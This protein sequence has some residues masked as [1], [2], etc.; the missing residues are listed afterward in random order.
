MARNNNYNALLKK[1]Q[2][3]GGYAVIKPNR[4]ALKT[5]EGFVI[6]VAAIYESA[7]DSSPLKA[8][9]TIFHSYDVEDYLT[10]S[11]IKY[12]STRI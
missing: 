7:D 5:K 6:W 11:D 10:D 9:D 8:I 2:E 3:K 12:L 4:P 1:V